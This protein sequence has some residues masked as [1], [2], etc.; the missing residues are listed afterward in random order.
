MS[1]PSDA[2]PLE[3]ADFEPDFLAACR[4]LAGAPGASPIGSAVREVH[5]RV[6]VLRMLRP[7]ACRRLL[8]GIDERRALAPAVPPNSMHDHGALLGP[9]GFDDLLAD[10]REHW[11][12]PLAARLLPEFAGRGLDTH[13]GYLVE[14]AHDRDEELGFHV[15][16]SEVTLNLCLGDRFEGAELTML[17]LRCDL[18]R[19]SPVRR[20]EM[21]EHVHEPGLA[22]LHAGRHRH[23]VEPIVRGSRRNLILWC[24]SS[25]LRAAASGALTCTP[26]CDAR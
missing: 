9:L 16:D 24:R 21:F 14:Y 15:D 8:A 3:E 18:H 25:A 2:R 5:P 17:G 11:I 6:Y 13:H 12:A 1:R 22:V 10:L 20:E 26:W 23:R 4:A 19:Q 7:E